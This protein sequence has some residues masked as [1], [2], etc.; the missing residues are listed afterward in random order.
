L[1]CQD[2]IE[3]NRVQAAHRDE[4]FGRAILHIKQAAERGDLHQAQEEAAL[5]C[6]LWP[7]RAEAWL[8]RAWL[9]DAPEEALTH[10]QQAARLEPSE[11]TTQAVRWAEARAH[12]ATTDDRRPTTDDGRRT[13]DEPGEPRWGGQGWLASSDLF[14][15]VV[16]QAGL[17]YEWAKAQRFQVRPVQ[18]VS[19]VGVA[20]ILLFM[21][22][23]GGVGPAGASGA[24]PLAARTV[25]TKTAQVQTL[26]EAKPA[27]APKPG[28]AVPQTSPSRY[29]LNRPTLAA[30]PLSQLASL[31]AVLN[32]LPISRQPSAEPPLTFAMPAPL[33]PAEVDA[34]LF[35]ADLLE[36]P[37]VVATDTVATGAGQTVIS[38]TLVTAAVPTDTA[39]YALW[40]ARNDPVPYQVQTGENPTIIAQKFGLD[41]STIIW[42]N[43]TLE[44][45]PELL[46]VGQTLLIPALDGVLHTVKEG[47]TLNSLA[48]LYKVD[49][50]LIVWFPGNGLSSAD[51]PLQVGQNIMVPGGRK[52]YVAPPAAP[53][54]PQR[55]A[56]Q[57]TSTSNR[58][59]FA[60]PTGGAISQASHAYHVALDIAAPMNT[61]I[62]ASAGGTIVYSG[63]DDSGYGYTI[64]IDHGNRW[65]TRYAHLSGMYFEVG[66]WVNQGELIALMGSTGRSTG[67]HL[68][69]EILYNGWRYNPYDYLG[70]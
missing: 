21:W 44:E 24:K 57:S 58:G 8:W 68:H 33:D 69:F 64:L 67:P 30:P 20:A 2:S 27:D 55:V 52:P 60:W 50:S 40:P 42:A 34:R 3:A 9:C 36:E 62:Y 28:R 59:Y 66:D 41:L 47:D 37:A 18:L 63:W 16:A 39:A 32:A 14:R 46:S 19:I 65:R 26:A 1:T 53:A 43:G 13:T 38:T 12:K 23:G 54:P 61:P 49:V 22:T 56:Q 35:G 29:V 6:A 48:T 10:A 51:A 4:S 7:Q 70:R 5:A 11:V 15:R 25:S 17:Y 31:A 45:N